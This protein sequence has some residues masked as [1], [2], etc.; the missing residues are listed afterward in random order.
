MK[1]Q[2]INSGREMSKEN[3]VKL[4]ELQD[5]D[6]PFMLE[7]M[8]DP[9]IQ[10]RFKK[11]MMTASEDDALRFIKLSREENINKTGSSLHCAIVNENDEYLGTVSLKDIDYISKTAE[12]AITLRTKMHG[13][14]YG[15]IATDL[16]LR[17][18]FEELGLHRVFLNVYANNL[19]AIRLYEKSGF[20][21]EG[22]FRDHN[23]IDGKYV[24]LKWYGMLEDE[25]RE[26]HK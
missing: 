25:F 26:T 7:W 13:N 6:A 23:F 17:K 19:A 11:D 5:K 1:N 3:M 18:G 14:G 8:H 15:Y 12:F 20:K 21:L 4:R 22:E 9:E 10:K 2:N 16:M 24:N